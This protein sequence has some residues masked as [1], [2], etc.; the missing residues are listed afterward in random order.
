MTVS[1]M[2]I[3]S[4]WFDQ[5]LLLIRSIKAINGQNNWKLVKRIITL[6][7]IFLLGTG[8]F[9]PLRKNSPAQF[10]GKDKKFLVIASNMAEVSGAEW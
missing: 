8:H 3:G 4:K 2:E 7:Y 5:V 9:L 10:A 1:I 6:D